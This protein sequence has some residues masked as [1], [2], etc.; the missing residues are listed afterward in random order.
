MISLIIATDLA[1]A[2]ESGLYLINGISGL[3]CIS[4]NRISIGNMSVLRG[5]IVNFIFVI[6]D[7]L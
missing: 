4:L 5:C 7:F 6:V 3:E 1:R 2:L